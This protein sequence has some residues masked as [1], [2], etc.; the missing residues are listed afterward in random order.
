VRSLHEIDSTPFFEG[1]LP[2]EE[3]AR[4]GR[5]TLRFGPMK[6]VGL[7]DPRTGGR[8]HAV[9]QLRQDNL[10][11]IRVIQAFGQER[12]ELDRFTQR[13]TWDSVQVTPLRWQAVKFG[14]DS[15]QGHRRQAIANREAVPGAA[16]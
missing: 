15:L 12:H 2:I 11:G 7:T 3:M 5:D 4:R 1:C 8:A 14:F 9:V 10:A 6:P 16:C 13:S